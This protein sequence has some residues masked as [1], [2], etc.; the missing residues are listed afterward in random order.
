[1]TTGFNKKMPDRGQAVSITLLSGD[2]VIETEG[3]YH[4]TDDLGPVF[5]LDKPVKSMVWVRAK[6]KDVEIQEL[7][8]ESWRIIE[9]PAE[10]E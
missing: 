9:K 4:K 6:V 5:K 3:T 2:E 1:M 10:S 8:V 7:Y